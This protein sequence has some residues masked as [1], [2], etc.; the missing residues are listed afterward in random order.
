MAACETTSSY[1]VCSSIY[2][3]VYQACI[4]QA[5]NYEQNEFADNQ[6]TYYNCEDGCRDG[7]CDGHPPTGLLRIPHAEPASDPTGVPSSRT[8][9]ALAGTLLSLPALRSMLKAVRCRTRLPAQSA[10]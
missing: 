8:P 3:P 1:S 10:D 6:T 9:L 4:A 2:G 7:V 5:Y